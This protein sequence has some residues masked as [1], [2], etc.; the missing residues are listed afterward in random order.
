MREKVEYKKILIIEDDESLRKELYDHF[1]QKNTVLVAGSVKKAKKILEENLFDICLMDIILPDGSGLNLFEHLVSIP[2]IILSNLGS[3]E[4]LLEGFSHGAIDYIVKPASIEIIEARMELRLLPYPHHKINNHG[5][6]LNMKTRTIAYKNQDLKLTSS[7]FNILLFL[8]RN[9][10]RFFTA[11]EI[12]EHVWKMPY[13]NT[14][15]I[16]THLSNLRKK[17]LSISKEC[18][19]LILTEFGKGYS[20]IGGDDYNETI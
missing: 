16:K 12:Y 11:S 19:D 7:E 5:L 13:L 17:M 20:F 4:M 1:C 3:D 6:E 14:T 18:S 15:T 10:N 2:T 9:P 8:M